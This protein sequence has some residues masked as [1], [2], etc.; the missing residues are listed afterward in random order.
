[1]CLAIYK[2]GKLAI[3]VEHLRDG[4]I[5]NPDGGGYAYIHEGKVVINK[6]FVKLQEF[7]KSY[8]SDFKKHKDSPFLI[9][10][11]IRSMGDKSEDN[12]HPFPIDGGA[13]IHNGSLQGTGAQYQQG[14]S[15]TRLFAEKF[16]SN[17]SFK[18]MNEHKGEFGQAVGAYNK[19]VFLYETGQ[20][21]IVNED[22]GVWRN[23]I[24]YSNHTFT[25]R[26]SSA[27]SNTLTEDWY[28]WPYD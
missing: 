1:M 24:W 8:E 17:L 6:G 23:D 19:L 2:P 5:A 4:W 20:V 10:F 11:R 16:K 25:P 28:N 18:F 3:P 12:T 7:L 27:P 14:P 26:P 9:H 15:D 13:V 21:V 22:R